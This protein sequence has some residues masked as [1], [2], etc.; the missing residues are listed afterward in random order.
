MGKPA[1]RRKFANYTCLGAGCGLKV[2]LRVPAR[3][4]PKPRP[5]QWKMV[6]ARYQDAETGVL[7]EAS[8]LFCSQRCMER[9]Q[10]AGGLAGRIQAYLGPA[11]DPPHRVVYHCVKCDTTAELVCPQ[12]TQAAVAVPEGWSVVPLVAVD[13]DSGI[14]RMTSMPCCSDKCAGALDGEAPIE[15]QPEMAQRELKR[16]FADIVN[17]EKARVLGTMPA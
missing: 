14:A 1:K 5:P 11:G 9:P 6:R 13:Y 2:R 3:T 4:G 15:E 8:I 12:H 10:E 7:R 16:L 17:E